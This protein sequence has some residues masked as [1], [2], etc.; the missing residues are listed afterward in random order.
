[1]D[2]GKTNEA[3][4]A[5]LVRDFDLNISYVEEFDVNAED[6]LSSPILMNTQPASQNCIEVSPS[7]DCI[8][9]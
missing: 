9:S 4:N 6:K 2:S 8:C 5:K 3:P 1:M 7:N